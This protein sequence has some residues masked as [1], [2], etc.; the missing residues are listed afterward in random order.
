MLVVSSSSDGIP[1]YDFDG[2]VLRIRTDG[3]SSYSGHVLGCSL[4][5]ISA[6]C[7]GLSTVL[8]QKLEIR[9]TDAYLT[10]SG[11]SATVYTC[12]FLFLNSHFQWESL[13]ELDS[14]ICSLLALNGIVSS[15]IGTN[16]FIRAMMV[17]SPVTVN[18]LWS[19]SIPIS[20]LVDFYRGAIH[21]LNP[22]FLFGA[23][24][25]LLSTVMVPFEQNDTRLSDA[26]L[27]REIPLLVISDE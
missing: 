12:I 21:T 15:V 22:I 14:E 24:L 25:V 10:V 16:L 18:V 6:V 11:L 19:L 17:L 7:S 13:S 27:R 23:L 8:F 1:E 26:E 9:H 5:L 2:A 3:V 4:A 20:V